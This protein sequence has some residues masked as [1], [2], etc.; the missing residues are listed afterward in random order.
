[1]SPVEIP[2]PPVF[3]TTIGERGCS[4]QPTGGVNATDSPWFQTLS[5]RVFPPVGV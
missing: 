3:G 5:L 4:V 1:M 2:A